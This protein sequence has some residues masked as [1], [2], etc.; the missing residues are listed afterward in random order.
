M[1]RNEIIFCGQRQ[2][3]REKEHSVYPTSCEYCPANSRSPFSVKCEFRTNRVFVGCT[4]GLI[5]FGCTPSKNIIG[6]KEYKLIERF[7]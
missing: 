1:D 5:A 2:F 6:S 3:V 7:G 4:K